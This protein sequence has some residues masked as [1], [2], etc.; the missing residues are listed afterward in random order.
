MQKYSMCYAGPP[1]LQDPLLSKMQL[2]NSLLRTSDSWSEF[3]K[4]FWKER[5]KKETMAIE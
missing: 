3:E 4:R 5:K 2:F 1:C